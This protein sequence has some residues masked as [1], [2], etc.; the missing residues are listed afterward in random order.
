M[1]YETRVGPGSGPH[2]GKLE[3]LYKDKWHFVKWLSRRDLLKPG[4]N[5]T[6]TTQGEH[7]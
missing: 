6:E 1:Q 3:V 4:L 7:K 2:A 5:K